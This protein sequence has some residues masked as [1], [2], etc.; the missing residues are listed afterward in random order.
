VR[1]RRR[2]GGGGNRVRCSWRVAVSACRRQGSGQE[3][4]PRSDP[5]SPGGGGGGHHKR[6][7]P[8]KKPPTREPVWG[9]PA[10][11]PPKQPPPRGGGGGGGNYNW[12]G[13]HQS[14]PPGLLSLA[15][16]HARKPSTG[17]RSL[18]LIMMTDGASSSC[19]FKTGKQVSCSFPSR[20][21][22]TAPPVG[23]LWLPGVQISR[24]GQGRVGL[25]EKGSWSIIS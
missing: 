18:C 25:L 3:H 5:P 7:W 4:P 11:P 21:T 19:C 20:T 6:G 16:A 8:T 15:H 1:A 2:H 12:C 10:P 14:P 22:R 9:T 13:Q 24:A 23:C 17:A